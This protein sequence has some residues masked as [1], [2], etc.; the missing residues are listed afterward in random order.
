MSKFHSLGPSFTMGDLYI[1]S[2]IKTFYIT[3]NY[4]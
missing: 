4:K 2:N 1:S 3:I